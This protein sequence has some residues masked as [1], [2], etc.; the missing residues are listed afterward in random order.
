MRLSSPPL[1]LEW[2]GWRAPTPVLQ[3]H[4][5]EFAQETDYEYGGCRLII[6][7]PRLQ[8]AAVTERIEEDMLIAL[9]L[10]PNQHLPLVRIAHMNYVQERLTIASY[11][12]PTITRVDME[13]MIDVSAASGMFDPRTIFRETAA[14]LLVPEETVPGLL[15][16]IQALQEPARQERLQEQVRQHARDEGTSIISAQIIQFGKVA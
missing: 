11:K 9:S 16:R 7:H 3:R 13:P 15:E 6:H 12:P 10:N 1:E 2:L 5:W 4:G 14:G 8:A